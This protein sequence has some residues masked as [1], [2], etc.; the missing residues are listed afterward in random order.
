M[1]TSFSSEVLDD[2]IA[3]AT[4]CAN[5]AESSEALAV[6][7]SVPLESD[8]SKCQPPACQHPPTWQPPACH[9]PGGRQPARYPPACHP[10]ACQ[11][12][13]RQP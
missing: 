6:A 10:P 13:T 12:P 11:P 7:L 9:R 5:P 2:M 8:W 4:S 3:L 1:E